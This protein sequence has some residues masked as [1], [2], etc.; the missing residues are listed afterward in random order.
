MRTKVNIA[1]T[2][3]KDIND[4]LDGIIK[5]TLAGKSAIIND[6]LKKSFQSEKTS[7]NVGK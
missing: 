4:I 7:G 5:E 2:I 1:I 3:D 6:I